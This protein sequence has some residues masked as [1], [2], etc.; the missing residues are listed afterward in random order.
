[1]QAISAI[2]DETRSLSFTAPGP[3]A[4]C[5]AGAFRDLVARDLDP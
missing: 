1:V 2:S 3:L 4:V 5:L